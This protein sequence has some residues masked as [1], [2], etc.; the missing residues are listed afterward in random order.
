MRGRL[1][2]IAVNL[3][4]GERLV[5]DV[6][7]EQRALRAKRRAQVPE[8]RL[9]D[10]NLMQ[11]LDVAPGNRQHAE[12]DPTLEWIRRETPLRSGETERDQQGPRQDRVGQRV[13]RG[14]ELL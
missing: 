1:R 4:P 12:L 7:M 13:R 3:Q 10:E 11:A 2:T 5:D 9:D 14:R 8:A 6:A